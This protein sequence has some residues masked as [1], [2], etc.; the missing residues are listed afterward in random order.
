[1]LSVEFR[2]GESRSTRMFCTSGSLPPHSGFLWLMNKDLE[3]SVKIIKCSAGFHRHRGL[4]IILRQDDQFVDHRSFRGLDFRFSKPASL[5]Q[6]QHP[7]V[8]GGCPGTADFQKPAL[9]HDGF[10]SEKRNRHI[11]LCSATN[12]LPWRRTTIFFSMLSR[13][14]GLCPD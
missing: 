2:E 5:L 3:L 12:T 1:M 10:D 13:A 14:F 9:G 6:V 11:G 8:E 4:E 7:L